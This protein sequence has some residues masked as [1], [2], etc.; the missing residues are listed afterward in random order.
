ME[1]NISSIL[2][3]VVEIWVLF[4]LT[5]VWSALTHIFNYLSTF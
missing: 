1:I 4:H 2:R 5:L 3:I